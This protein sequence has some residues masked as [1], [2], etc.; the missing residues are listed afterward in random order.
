MADRD[1]TLKQIRIMG[2]GTRGNPP[3]ILN[4]S[5]PDL[6]DIF[7]Q[8]QRGLSNRSIARNLLKMGMIGSENSLQQAVSLLRKRIGPILNQETPG[9]TP[10][11]SVPKLPAEISSLPQD[12]TLATVTEIVKSYGENIRQLS[13]AASKSGALVSE[14]L[15]KHIKSYNALVVTKTRLEQTAKPTRPVDPPEDYE[16]ITQERAD[17]VWGFITHNGRDVDKWTKMADTFIRRLEKHIVELDE[18]PGDGRFS[19]D[20]EIEQLEAPC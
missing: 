13:D 14:D 8:M 7:Q 4:L 5:N 12:D 17:R 9:R 15:A 2:R 16:E 6:F 11:L 1:E 18:D 19:T 20:E 10:P 3:A